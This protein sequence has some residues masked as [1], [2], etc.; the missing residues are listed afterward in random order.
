MPSFLNSYLL[1][2]C[3]FGKRIRKPFWYWL[4]QVRKRSSF[5]QI[6]ISRTS[7]SRPFWWLAYPL[8]MG[9]PFSWAKSYSRQKN[10]NA[11]LKQKNLTAPGQL[12]NRK[13]SLCSQAPVRGLNAVG[14]RAC[15]KH[16]YTVLA[17]GQRSCFSQSR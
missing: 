7:A 8:G 4:V 5:S 6:P 16:F 12:L 15:Y 9:P 2:S 11:L 1:F 14:I 13:T 17:A 10:L 3:Y